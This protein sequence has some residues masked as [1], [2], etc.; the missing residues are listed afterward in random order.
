LEKVLVTGGAGFI[1]SHLVE[2]LLSMGIEVRVLDNLFRGSRENLSQIHDKNLVFVE[3]DIL[4]LQM[5]GKVAAGVDTVFHLAAIN[6]TRYFYEQP[7]RVLEVNALGTRNVLR[8][9]TEQKVNRVIFASSSEVYGSPCHFPTAEDEPP[10]YDPPGERRWSYAISKLFGE[11]LCQ[12]LRDE[13]KVETV[14]FR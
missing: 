9:A 14:V 1:G 4:D 7:L 8:V 2:K 11:Q 10:Y 3:G 13:S 5:L 6:G 12:C